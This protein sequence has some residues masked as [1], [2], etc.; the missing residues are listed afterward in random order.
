MV[1]VAEIKQI[2]FFSV[3]SQKQL[4]ELSKI[5]E[6]RIYEEG[7]LVYQRGYVADRIY[8]VTKGLISLN[9]L[10]PVDKIGISFEKRGQGELSTC[11]KFANAILNWGINV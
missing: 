8:V 4:E 10:E 9:R 1:E 7:A 3:F 2:D 11:S 5:T 6:K